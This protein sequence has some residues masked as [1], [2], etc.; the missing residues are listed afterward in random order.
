MSRNL[1]KY[2]CNCI[3]CYS[4]PMNPGCVKNDN[5]CKFLMQLV[6]SVYWATRSKSEVAKEKTVFDKLIV[7]QRIFSTPLGS[8]SHSP[9]ARTAISLVTSFGVLGTCFKHDALNVSLQYRQCG[10]HVCWNIDWWADSENERLCMTVYVHLQLFEYSF[11]V[12]HLPVGLRSPGGKKRHH[13][14]SVLHLE[15]Y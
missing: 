11:Y 7:V 9:A 3:S 8:I 14:I 5:S 12:E 13:K 2:W 15:L 10:Q 4:F 6:I 1:K